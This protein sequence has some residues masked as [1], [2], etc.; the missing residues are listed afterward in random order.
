MSALLNEAFI[1]HIVH[2][3]L[4]M[5]MSEPMKTDGRASL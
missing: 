4:D 2:L 3:F 1:E 5:D